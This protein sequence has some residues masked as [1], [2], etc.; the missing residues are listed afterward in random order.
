MT[1]FVYVRN[2]KSPGAHKNGKYLGKVLRWYYAK[3]EIGGIYTVQTNNKVADSE[4]GKPIQDLPDT[5]PDD[6]D[7]EKYINI[8]TDMLYD[9]GYLKRL[10]QI[11]FF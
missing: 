4:G 3:G 2:A 7:Y 8:T 9:I 1:R 10:R 6:I 5:F 11:E